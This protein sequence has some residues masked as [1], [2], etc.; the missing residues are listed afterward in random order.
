MNGSGLEPVLEIFKKTGVHHVKLVEEQTVPDGNF[1]TCPYPNPEEEEALVLGIE[2]CKKTNADI[3]IATDPDSDRIGV[4]AKCGKEY[5][6]L[7]GNQLGVLLLDYLLEYLKNN[8]LLPENPLVLK[9]IVTT[10]MAEKIVAEYG[11][12]VINTLSGFKY[13]GEFIGKLE[14]EGQL[15]RFVLGLE[16]SCGY[17]IGP[18]V[19]DKDAVGTAML[20]C[21]MAEVYKEQGKTLWDRL[22]ELYE[23]YGCFRTE[24]ETQ[25]YGLAEAE[26]KMKRLRERLKI[27]ETATYD[28]Q[29][30]LRYEDYLEGLHGLPKSNVLKF[31][32]KNGTTVVIRPSGTEPKIK[33]YREKIVF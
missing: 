11:V 21:E 33:I 8:Q 17:L 27:F 9:T 32:L 26:E 10:T 3:L 4:V 23:K 15:E 13:I 16:E 7:S 12:Q 1:S 31:W 22:D 24:L 2:L 5:K 25:K 20:V 18:Y 19:R 30:I 14:E 29:K 28:G 6:H